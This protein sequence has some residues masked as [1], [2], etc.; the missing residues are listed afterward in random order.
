MKI[1]TSAGTHS[2]FYYW[3]FVGMRRLI[4]L[5]RA[6]ELHMGGSFYIFLDYI[7]EEKEMKISN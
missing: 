2:L 1:L 6:R 4:G 7:V 3:C 5:S